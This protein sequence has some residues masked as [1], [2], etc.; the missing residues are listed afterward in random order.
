MLARTVRSALAGLCTILVALA[1]PHVAAADAGPVSCPAGQT[2][3]A[4]AG[5]CVIVVVD[6]G[7]S[8]AGGDAGSG[9][10]TVVSANY[11][12][13]LPQC[14]WG[15]SPIPCSGGFGYWNNE[16]MCYVGRA[17]TPYPSDSPI[18]EGHHPEGAIYSCYNPFIV[19]TRNYDF[20]SATQ[21]AGPAA[22]PDPRLLA[23]RAVAT[24]NLRAI[25][26]GIVPEPVAGSVGLVG[27]PNWMWVDNPTE[28]S[29]GPIT[30]TATAGAYT[31]TAT[32]K[33]SQVDWD[34]G[35]GEVVTCGAGTAYEDAYG[36]SSSPTCG[37][38]YTRQG[39]YTVRATSHWLIT[40]SGIGQSGTIP[41]DLAQSARVTIGEAQVLKQ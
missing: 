24:M 25:T 34:M 2:W 15:G 10:G 6:R 41:L 5:T 32:A 39:T 27:M 3:N 26:V 9:S 37:H 28:N 1:F 11:R 12:G 20:W 40:W 17:L 33:V 4:R 21:P 30:R 35:D 18:W 38:T 13:T 19:G 22:P 36:K 8:G 29:F 7:G 14:V 23:E 31:V 16:L